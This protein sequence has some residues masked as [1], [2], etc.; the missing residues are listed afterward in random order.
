MRMYNFVRSRQLEG[1]FELNGSIG[2][3]PLMSLRICKG[4]GNPPEDAWPYNGNAKD[5]PPQD[6]PKEIDTIAKRNTWIGVLKM[7][8]KKMPGQ[9][10]PLNMLLIIKQN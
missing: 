2:V 5:W 8:L 9:D 3:F 4:W 1:T 6:E 7:P 10:N